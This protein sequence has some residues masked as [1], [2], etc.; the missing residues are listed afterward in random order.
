ME[1]EA[2]SGFHAGR[3][4]QGQALAELLITTPLLVAV[5]A[6]GLAL[7]RLATAE[8]EVRLAAIVGASAADPVAA[9][10]RHLQVNGMVNGASAAVQVRQLAWLREVT[11]TAR[12]PLGWW[13]GANGGTVR[14]LSAAAGRGRAL[15]CIRSGR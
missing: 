6:G 8:A 5:A 3:R 7:T 4:E 10:K 1:G 2:L 11:V 12:V 9:A 15:L 14:E 13:P